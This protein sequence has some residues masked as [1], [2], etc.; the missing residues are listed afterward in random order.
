M[1]FRVES[2]VDRPAIFIAITLL[3]TGDVRDEKSETEREVQRT[4]ER[5]ES[6]RKRRATE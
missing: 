2:W 1:G 6:N 5:E 4:T 3:A